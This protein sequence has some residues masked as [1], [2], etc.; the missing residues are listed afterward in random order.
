MKYLL[1]A[2]TLFSLL[3]CCNLNKDRKLSDQELKELAKAH[4][5]SVFVV[6]DSMR[7]LNIYVPPLYD[8]EVFDSATTVKF[9]E[10]AKATQGELKLLVNSKLISTEII[11]IIKSNAENNAD[12]LILMDKTG[13]MADEIDN[14][15]K[16]LIQITAALKT[17][18]NVRLGIGLYGDKNDDGTDWFSFRNFETDYTAATGF[19][20]R[21]EVTGGGDYPES[22][23]EGFFKACEQNFWRSQTKRMIILIGDAPPLENPLSKYQVTDVIK[24][25]EEDKIKMNFYPIVVTPMSDQV[26]NTAAAKTFEKE[27]IVAN[28][29]PNPASDIVNLNLVTNDTYSIEIFNAAGTSILAD[30]FSGN[31]WKRD[32]SSLPNGA[33]IA[34]VIRKDKKFETIKFVVFR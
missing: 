16:G 11:N 1:I 15:K 23:Y 29:F 21:I 14:V 22:V 10:L 5:D 13:S 27:K 9:F 8:K 24:K 12:L 7:K 32:V 2:T 25:A 17:F 26:L 33:Y 28:L 6:V 18:N 30:K 31:L 19:I 34:R 20:N 3:I 4:D